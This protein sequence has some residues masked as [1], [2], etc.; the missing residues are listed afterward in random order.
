MK[1]NKDVS[2]GSKDQWFLFGLYQHRLTKLGILKNDL[3]DKNRY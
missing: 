2:N 1:N 3:A